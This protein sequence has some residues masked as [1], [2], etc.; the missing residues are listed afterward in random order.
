MIAA[1][2]KPSE[3]VALGTA[4]DAGWEMAST[5]ESITPAM[6]TGLR[7]IR[8]KVPGTVASALREQKAWRMGDRARF[9][10]SEH[11]FRCRFNAAAL[12]PGEEIILRIG[13]IATVA[14]V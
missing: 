10:A 1:Y 5:A 11:W 7:F 9:D 14:E 2:S 12:A 13:G 3:D 6:V 8:A 4:L